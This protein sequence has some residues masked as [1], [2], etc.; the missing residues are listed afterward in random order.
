M[1]VYPQK[2]F[3]WIIASSNK[4]FYLYIQKNNH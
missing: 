3:K 4:R 2:V 1:I